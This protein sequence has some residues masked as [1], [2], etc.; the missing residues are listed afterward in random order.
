MPSLRALSHNSAAISLTLASTT[1]SL[2]PRQRIVA[3]P[4]GLSYLPV[5]LKI[6][7]YLVIV[8][9]RP[10]PR[11]PQPFQLQQKLRNM[12]FSRLFGRIDSATC[13]NLM[14]RKSGFRGLLDTL[15]T[16]IL[17]AR[18]GGRTHTALRPPDFESGASAS[19]AIRARQENIIDS[20][21]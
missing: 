8:W 15:D 7:W 2:P 11:N 17:G 19:S 5:R 12:R 6:Q 10:P 21:A 9:V 1:A 13:C 20:S 18:R 3:N 14:K 16:V 4:Y